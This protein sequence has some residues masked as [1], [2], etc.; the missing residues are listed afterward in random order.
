MGKRQQRKGANGERELTQILQSKGYQVKRGGSQTYGEI[1]DI[2]GLPGVHIEVK[3]QERLDLIG[4][5]QQAET[6]AIKFKD[7]QPAVFHRKNRSKWLVT[8]SL[9]E[10]LTL[11]ET[12]ESCRNLPVPW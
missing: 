4:A 5:I 12:A 9:D 2:V 10:W 3:R 1:P 8:M 11:Y 6:D 7:G